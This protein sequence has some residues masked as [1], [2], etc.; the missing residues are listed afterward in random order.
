[1]TALFPPP[2]HRGEV[3]EALRRKLAGAERRVVQGSVVPTF[4][5]D[6]FRAQ[7]AQY[8]FA[9]ARPLGEV[10]D[11]AV[12]TMEHGLVHINHPRYFGLFN[13]TPTFPAQCA[14]QIIASF[15]PQ[16][17]TATTSPAA[18]DIEAHVIRAVG[19]RAGLP[20]GAC[21]HFTTGGAEAN[22]T[23]LVLA[24]TRAHPDFARV[25]ARAFSGQPVFYVSQDS[26]L[27]WLKIAH[28]VG[29]GRDAVRLVNTDGG[30]RLHVAALRAMLFADRAEGCVPVMI[31]AT[32]GTTNAGMIDPLSACVDIARENGAWCHVDAAWAGALVADDDLRTE[33]AGI[34]EADSI[35]IDAHKWFA[36]TMGCGMVLL[37]DPALLSTAFQASNTYMPSNTPQVDP[38]VTSL[39]WS[40]RFVGLRLFLSLA[41]AGWEGYADHVRRAVALA[42]TLRERLTEKGWTIVNQS[43][44]AVLCAVPPDPNA[45][46]TIVRRVVASGNAWVSTAVFEGREVVRT[47]IT[48][49]L[50]TEDDIS[51]LVAALADHD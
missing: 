44:A 11:W 27:A 41:A 39:Q 25:G 37:R 50:T 51:A 4:D 49:G 21:G 32:A 24:L 8:D 40:R 18:V 38:Y 45:V 9:Q 3:A 6:G 12:S 23:A 47:C 26:H 7:L 48:S 29:I 46:R 1:M 35:T 15:N 14:D 31:G 16:L 22:C 30:G 42:A 17:A 13:P 36:T 34:E 2:D 28:Q 10:M 43:P 20:A 5:L 19:R 33:L